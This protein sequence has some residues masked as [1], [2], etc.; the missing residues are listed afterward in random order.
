[1]LLINWGWN[2]GL[3]L[4]LLQRSEQDSE[5]CVLVLDAELLSDALPVKLDRSS[6]NVE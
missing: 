2:T 6:G 1:M 3:E 5:V 4:V